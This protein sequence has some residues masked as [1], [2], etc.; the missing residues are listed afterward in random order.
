MA[1]DSLCK[2]CVCGCCVCREL[3]GML[4]TERAMGDWCVLEKGPSS[5]MY[6]CL[7]L[8]IIDSHKRFDASVDFASLLL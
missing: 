5:L 3:R 2:Y 1:V 7:L 8:L 6:V 4:T